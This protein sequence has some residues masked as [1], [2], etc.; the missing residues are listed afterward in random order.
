[1][2]SQAGIHRRLQDF[3]TKFLPCFLNL[4]VNVR[5]DSR[6]INEKFSICAS[7]QILVSEINAC[8]RG[9]VG[10]HGKYYIRE[11]GNV[12]DPIGDLGVEFARYCSSVLSVQIEDRGYTVTAVTQTTSHV[13]TH[14]T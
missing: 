3:R 8:H 11:T 5:T 9:I 2:M 6:A 7:E 14:A 4:D 12:R 10:N 1:G 13:R